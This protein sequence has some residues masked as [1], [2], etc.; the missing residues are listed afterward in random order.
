MAKKIKIM[1]ESL[2]PPV[3]AQR[4]SIAEALTCPEVYE[5]Y[6]AALYAA[7]ALR[8]SP[9]G[10]RLALARKPFSEEMDKGDFAGPEASRK[11]LI[12]ALVIATGLSPELATD[13][14]VDRAELHRVAYNRLL[15]YCKD[16]A[17][18]RCLEKDG[19]EDANYDCNCK[20]C[21]AK[22]ALSV[23]KAIEMSRREKR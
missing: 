5:L 19:Y 15:S 16:D 18:Q 4:V 6:Y 9:Q 11:E 10:S 12:E 2:P 1:P 14:P 17:E 22:H 7:A 3:D 21:K 8:Q 23:H 20:P 13:G